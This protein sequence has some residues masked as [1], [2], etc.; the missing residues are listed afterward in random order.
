[1]RADA[2]DLDIGRPGGR[3]T[4]ILAW[5]S[6]PAKGG[7]GERVF[8]DAASSAMVR[9]L[10]GP[11]RADHRGLRAPGQP[12]PRR[13]KQYSVNPCKV[14]GRVRSSDPAKPAIKG[15]GSKRLSIC[16]ASGRRAQQPCRGT[17]TATHG[18]ADQRSHPD[19]CGNADAHSASIP[20]ALR[21]AHQAMTGAAS[22][23]ELRHDR[24]RQAMR[25]GMRLLRTAGPTSASPHPH[26]DGPADARRHGAGSGPHRRIA[27]YRGGRAYR[28]TARRGGRSP[29]ISKKAL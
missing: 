2:G 11:L 13:P 27:A 17:D 21:R 12:A 4:S 22:E 24:Q 23:A 25:A 14:R 15:S 3:E 9:F 16:S 20:A 8:I 29:A 28:Q 7:S 1:M 26:A 6:H 18:K 19:R 5:L 10:V